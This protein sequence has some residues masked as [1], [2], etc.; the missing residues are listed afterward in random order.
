M[1][2]KLTDE[3]WNN[4]GYISNEPCDICGDVYT[5]VESRFL[6]ATCRKHANVPP[7]NRANY[8]KNKKGKKS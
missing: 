5:K 6:Y 2:K 8:K 4:F 3:E 7:V 1:V